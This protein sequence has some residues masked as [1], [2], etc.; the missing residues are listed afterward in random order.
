MAT[1]TLVTGCRK[2]NKG[3]GEGQAVFVHTLWKHFGHPWDEGGLSN[4]SWWH[5]GFSSVGSGLDEGQMQRLQRQGG[6]GDNQTSDWTLSVSQTMAA[7]SETL[8]N[9]FHRIKKTTVP[10][11]ERGCCRQIW[12]EKKKRVTSSEPLF[13]DEQQNNYLDYVP[14]QM[15]MIRWGHRELISRHRFDMQNRSYWFMLACCLFSC[16]VIDRMTETHRKMLVTV[17]THT[18]TSGAAAKCGSVPLKLI[19]VQVALCRTAGSWINYTNKIKAWRASGYSHTW[20]T[21]HEEWIIL[22]KQMFELEF[23]KQKRKWALN[24]ERVKTEE[25]FYQKWIP[26]TNIV[27]V[28]HP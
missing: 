22:E 3:R 6:W 18:H 28:L 21:R 11:L 24:E 16:P 5:W 1:K 9:G 10:S 23:L 15:E 14:V 20:C 8:Q 19:M 26:L 25:Q 13:T 4:P 17:K 12:E 27:R 2:E 7:R